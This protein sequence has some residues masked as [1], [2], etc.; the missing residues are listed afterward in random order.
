VEDLVALPGDLLLMTSDGLTRHVKDEEILAIVQ[1]SSGPE[2]ACNALV[3]RAKQR[4]G[5]DNI[6]CLLVKVVDQPWYRNIF[7]KLFHGGQ[8]W[9]N[10]I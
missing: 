9:Q 6:T 5:D 4:G 2:Q 1:Q 7:G 8:Q 10:S 3:E